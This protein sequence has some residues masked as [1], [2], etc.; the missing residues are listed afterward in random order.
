MDETLLLPTHPLR[1]TCRGGGC[2]RPQRTADPRPP[3]YSR[4]RRR[5]RRRHFPRASRRPLEALSATLRTRISN[6]VQ[7]HDNKSCTRVSGG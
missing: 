5:R 6:P 7:P 1:P 4:R 3:R 2:F